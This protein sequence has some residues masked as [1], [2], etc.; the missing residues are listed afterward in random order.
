M[1]KAVTGRP[2]RSRV[3]I[4]AGDDPHA[5]LAAAE[6]DHAPVPLP[7]P[8]GHRDRGR[9]GRLDEADQLVDLEMFESPVQRRAGGLG[10]VAL[11]PPV[12]PQQPADLDAR[13]ALRLPDTDPTDERAAR[14]LLHRPHPEPAQ[15]PVPDPQPDRPPA[16]LA[17]RGAVVGH[18]LGDQR[19]LG[20]GKQAIDVVCAEAAQQ[21]TL[22]LE[23]RERAMSVMAGT[24]DRR[25]GRDRRCCIR[26]VS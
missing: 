3:P 15:D 9:V 24:D 6:R 2:L 10:R 16:R 17:Q 7:N 5:G 26:S 12:A 4:L 22:R 20:Q 25:F 21:Q 14:P 8:L 1:S 18:V 13:P 19:V 23:R 11:T